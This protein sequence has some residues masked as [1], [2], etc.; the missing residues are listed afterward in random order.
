M[1]TTIPTQT[2]IP[3]ELQMNMWFWNKFKIAAKSSIFSYE[4]LLW[5]YLP[6][7]AEEY[8]NASMGM[9]KEELEWIVRNLFDWT[10]I[11]KWTQLQKIN[12]YHMNA[13]LLF[14]WQT[15]FDDDAT[16][17]RLWIILSKNHYKYDIKKLET[18]PYVL[19][20]VLSIYKDMDSFKKYMDRVYEIQQELKSSIQ[21]SR[22]NARVTYIYSLLIALW[23][24]L[25]LDEYRHILID[26]LKSQ[27]V[28]LAQ[29][30]IKVIYQKVFNLQ[31]LYNFDVSWHEW[32]IVINIVEEAIRSGSN[33]S[34]LRWFCKTINEHFRP[35]DTDLEWF[36][37]YID[38]K[39]LF[40]TKMLWWYF[41]KVLRSISFW[42]SFN[43]QQREAMWALKTWLNENYPKH[44][45]VQDLNYET[46]DQKIKN[47][48]EDDFI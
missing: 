42:W 9:K 40:K 29:D 25:W 2:E 5:Q 43:Q 30:D 45:I 44:P 36:N 31:V 4:K 34:D 27:D 47:R 39:Y 18:L 24:W 13:V 3:R 10:T 15:L 17:T 26:N 8:R 21:L 7:P 41:L 28:F 22:E 32:W 23:E 20:D 48:F 6:I 11:P 35:W 16:L 38:F 14:D 19:P 33:I 12:T 1:Q 46:F 37:V